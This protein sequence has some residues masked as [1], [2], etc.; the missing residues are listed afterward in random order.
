MSIIKCV[1]WGGPVTE[2]NILNTGH[3]H[4]RFHAI[5]AGSNGYVNQTV[6]AADGYSPA[7]FLGTAS[8]DAPQDCFGHD[9]YVGFK[10]WSD[11]RA[12]DSHRC[13]A[14][15]DAQNEYNIAHPSADGTPLKFCNFFNTYLLLKNDIVQGQTCSL[16]T[17]TWDKSYATYRGY[18]VG[19]D[20]Y[21][22]SH[23]YSFTHQTDRGG[24]SLACKK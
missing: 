17:K 13:A 18:R 22:I 21:S 7:T 15:C 1:F 19:S 16:Y 2:D 20:R 10:F 9:T 6:D 3:K 14:V 5:I 4:S 23:S 12:F 8:I 11:G 24:F